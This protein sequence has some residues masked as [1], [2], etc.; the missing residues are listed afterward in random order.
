MAPS[1]EALLNQNE[2]SASRSLKHNYYCAAHHGRRLLKKN[3][4]ELSDQ[5]MLQILNPRLIAAHADAEIDQRQRHDGKQEPE[6][7]ATV[8]VERGKERMM[9]HDGH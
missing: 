4:W 7:D 8:G 1:R 9:K 3:I 6:E 5:N 2:T